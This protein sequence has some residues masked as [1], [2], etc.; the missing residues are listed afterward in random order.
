M[1]YK[2]DFD[3][4]PEYV[5]IQTD[6]IALPVDFDNLLT[7]LVNSPRWRT[8]TN[9]IVDHRKLNITNL[10][11]HDMSIIK[12]IVRKYSEKLGEHRCAFIVSD[13][14]GFGTARMYEL[15]GGGD[16]HSEVNIFYSID[17]AV[18]WIRNDHAHS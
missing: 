10:K 17:E 2:I 6:S 3:H 9:L 18:K 11:S 1:K 16:I 14:L 5:L 4:L 12:D 8:G 7:E 13:K 15:M